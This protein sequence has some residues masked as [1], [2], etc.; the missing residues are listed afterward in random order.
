MPFSRQLDGV[1]FAR[2]QQLEA[3]ADIGFVVDHQ[4]AAL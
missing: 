3:F 4:D 2:Q 1:A